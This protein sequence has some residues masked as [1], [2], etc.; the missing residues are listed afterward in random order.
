V[1]PRSR[2]RV[3]RTLAV[4][5]AALVAA[6]APGMRSIGADATS[7]EI[8]AIHVGFDGK[9]KLGCW[10]QATVDLQ[11]ALPNDAN[12]I[13]VLAP[14]SDGVPASV[15]AYFERQSDPPHGVLSI[16]VGQ[17]SAPL[18]VRL[19]D[20]DHR[21]HSSGTFY[22][23]RD[24]DAGGYPA[25]LP[26]T[27]RLVVTYGAVTDLAATLA[28]ADNEASPVADVHS[29]LVKEP[30]SLPKK[31]Y[32]Y[33]SVDAVI[34]SGSDLEAFADAEDL[35]PRIAALN[36][37][38]ELGGR[39]VI[40]CGADSA[41]LLA[42]GAPLAPLL[43]GRYSGEVVPLPD[44][45]PLEAFAGA[46]GDI[47]RASGRDD[48][49]RVPRL[50]DIQG[51]LLAQGP[52]AT[53]L[54]LRARRGFGDVTFVAV[55]PESEPIANWEDR[56]S[57]LRQCLRWPSPALNASRD[58]SHATSAAADMT[59]VL[60]SALDQSFA[61]VAA[62]SFGL[63]ALLTLGYTALIGPVDYFFLRAIKRPSLTWLTF[64][65][66]VIVACWGAYALAN[67]MKGT[68][69]R[70]N[71]VEIVDVDVQTGQTRG[72]VWAHLFNANVD[73]YD[74]SLTPRFANK[75]VGATSDPR[76]ALSPD[77]VDMLLT[78]DIIVAPLG[79]A[80]FGLGAMQGQRAQPALF[81]QGYAF[82]SNPPLYSIESMPIEQWSTRTLTARW[83]GEVGATIDAQLR[84]R[85]DDELVGEL[86]NRTGIRLEDCVL[87][88]GN[89]AY[90]LPPLANGATYDLDRAPKPRTLR[91]TLTSVAA[92]DDPNARTADDGSVLFDPLSTDVARIAKLMMFYDAIGGAAYVGTPNRYQGFIDMSRLL[93][94][95]VAILLARAPAHRLAFEKADAA[96]AF[97]SSSL[98]INPASVDGR[99]LDLRPDDRHW[100]YYRFIIPLDEPIAETPTGDD[101]EA[102]PLLGPQPFGR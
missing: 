82:Q 61:D 30:E 39:L 27:A 4:A 5:A 77:R 24:A 15:G 69:N 6:F 66:V 70:V 3:L 76:E 34:L 95:D 22:P 40:F 64:P 37:W 96:K 18:K 42:D 8:A 14:D 59:N 99:F 12:R 80:G 50:V 94:G 75:P 98:D 85:G 68:Q 41:E 63:V 55:D 44:Y 53:P 57:F 31:W 92:G 11:G 100:T 88:R 90:N 16:R 33:E 46:A 51:Q 23:G 17:E 19:I 81:E 48:R 29:V 60:R 20:D 84:P 93:T 2:T 56:T 87:I 79:V 9:F 32:D 54:V 78:R 52:S 101:P 21:E 102:E 26:S 43:P 91:T 89:W 49:L 36:R 25:A 1:T 47:R 45:T 97:L 10:T 86:T 58:H 72:T 13:E 7:P 74:F 62:A 73:R 65:V 35:A 67:R 38:V 83:S 28:H 71:Q